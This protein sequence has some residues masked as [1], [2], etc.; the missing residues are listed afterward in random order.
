MT[1]Y[2]SDSWFLLRAAETHILVFSSLLAEPFRRSLLVTP[3]LPLNH[4]KM[5]STTTTNESLLDR[6]QQQQLHEARQSGAVAPAVDSSTG[7]IINPHNPEFLTKKPW[8]LGQGAAQPTLEHQQGLVELNEVSLTAAEAALERD[9]LQQKKDLVEGNFYK[10]QWVEALKRSKTPY[11][12]CQILNVYKKGDSIELDLQFEDKTIEKRVKPSGRNSNQQPR[13]RITRAGARTSNVEAQLTAG[14]NAYASKRD[15]YHGYDSQ[16]HNVKMQRKYE[17]REQIRKQLREDA[18]SSKQT[19]GDE[20]GKNATD[21]APSDSDYDSDVAGSDSD[22]EEFVQR[23]EDA[24]VI[25][26]HLA[27]QGGVGGAQMKVTARNL[28]I[29]EDTAKYLRN[30]DVDS[31]Y[32]DPK[33]RSMRDNP[34]PEISIE[35]SEFAGDGFQRATGDTVGLAETSLFAWDAERKGVDLH[36]IANP[37]QAEL[38]KKEFKAKATD[39]KLQRKQALFDKYGGKEHLDGNGG[40]AT[41]SLQDKS[42]AAIPDRKVRFGVDVTPKEY[43]QDGRLLKQGGKE[44]RQEARKSKYEEDVYMNGHTTVFGSFFHRG[45]FAWGYADDHSLIRNSYCT[46]ETGRLANDEANAMTFGTGEAGSAELA[47]ARGM[48]KAITPSVGEIRSTLESTLNNKSK[49]YGE[50]N[51]HVELD[52]EKLKRALKAADQDD[53]DKKKRK[54]HSMEADVNVTEED[55]EAYRLRKEKSSDPMAKIDSDKLLDY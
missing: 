2:R 9:R 36:P 49:L 19:G 16:S 39:I 24:K 7:Q 15:A 11:R 50:A 13:V 40:L 48:L 47:Q 41:A 31:A 51:Q 46:G 22:D 54:Y 33:S 1:V 43:N 20:N 14:K 17:Q 8:Y 6:R 3:T 27:R 10:G 32:Y 52:E 21:A 53:A 34:N 25:T 38:L 4:Y 5:S 44:V 18:A 12:I 28:R 26:T 35:E 30:L 29:R 42:S 55:M 45:A 37:S 23:D